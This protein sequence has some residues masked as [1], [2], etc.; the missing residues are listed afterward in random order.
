[1][2]K[3]LT[4]LLLL[5]LL[6]TCKPKQEPQTENIIIENV[7][8]PGKE[9]YVI[10]AT[11]D[12]EYL[13][14]AYANGLYAIRAAE[15]V[16]QKIKNEEV[17]SVAN[18]IA[19]THQKIVE[20]INE[21]ASSKKIS[22]PSDL[23]Q[24]QRSELNKLSEKEPASLEKMFVEQMENEHKEDIE[25]LEKISKESEDNEISTVAIACLTSLK[26]QLDE[27]IA[28]KERLEL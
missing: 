17:R 8:V 13:V 4:Y 9:K 6:I 1:M 24:L 16:K 11:K 20:D 22:L 18:K 19:I 10:D 7:E 26:S 25:L 12:A 21:I 28:I 27:V 2:G 5:T 23:N 15:I 3:N 14:D